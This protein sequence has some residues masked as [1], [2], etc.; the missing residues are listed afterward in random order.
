[1]KIRYTNAGKF[2]I[3]ISSD[4]PE[5]WPE[6]SRRVMSDLAWAM[7]DFSMITGNK[8]GFAICEFRSDYVHLRPLLRHKLLAAQALQN[9]HR[10]DLS[11]AWA[12]TIIYSEMGRPF[13]EIKPK[14]DRAAAFG[15]MMDEG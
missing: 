15:R 3:K 6:S 14:K 4:L 12:L 2:W 1:M 11:L 10:G 8:G 7:H 9:A 5:D 13:H